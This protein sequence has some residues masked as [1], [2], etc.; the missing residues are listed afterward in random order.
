MRHAIIESGVVKNAVLASPEYAAEQGWVELPEGAGIGW[1][2]ADGVFSAPP[3]PPPVVPSIVSMRQGRLALLQA[4]KLDDVDAAIAALPSPAKEAA[5]IEWEYAIE[6]K[7]DSQLVAQLAP[8]LG[9]DDAAL[10][11]LFIAAAAL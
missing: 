10:D 2:Y 11:A 6:V 8:S 7:R 1:L 9:L 3:A 5:Q 4:G